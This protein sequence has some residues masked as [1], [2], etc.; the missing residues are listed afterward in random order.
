M[1]ETPGNDA[2]TCHAIAL[3]PREYYCNLERLHNRNQP[4]LRVYRNFIGLHL[5]Y[6]VQWLCKSML[7]CS[8]VIDYQLVKWYILLSDAKPL[9]DAAKDFIVGDGAEDGAQVIE[10]VPKIL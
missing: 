5:N 10:A 6:V 7:N 1:L 2:G 3:K 4:F 8:P 9:E